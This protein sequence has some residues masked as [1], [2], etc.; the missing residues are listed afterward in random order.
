MLI[1]NGLYA[2]CWLFAQFPTKNLSNLDSEPPIYC[3]E[4]ILQFTQY[5]VLL[6]RLHTMLFSRVKYYLILQM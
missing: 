2:I 1:N 3:N 4:R 5:K 6:L